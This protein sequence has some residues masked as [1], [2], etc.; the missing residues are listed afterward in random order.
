MAFEKAKCDQC[1]LKKHWQKKG[2][3]SPVDFEQRESGDGGILILGEGPTKTD[4]SLERPFSDRYG[5]D[6]LEALKTLGLRRGDVSWGHV[7]G[8]RWPGDDPKTYVAKLRSMN[9]RRAR[10][11]GK[12]PLLSPVEAC[13]KHVEQH[14]K[15]SAAILPLGSLATKAVF[16]NNVRLDDVRGAP[17]LVGVFT[18]G[19]KEE[20]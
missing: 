7:I 17:S 14:M 13:R 5:A 11:S 12:P 10:K 2:C 1:P 18:T 19:S 4:M 9:R 6:L 16:G 3:W 8:C 20:P 15:K